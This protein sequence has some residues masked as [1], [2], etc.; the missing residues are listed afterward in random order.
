MSVSALEPADASHAFDGTR[1]PSGPTLRNVMRSEWTKLRSV[2]STW[3][4]LG[5]FLLI[6]LGL[7]ALVIWGNA[8]DYAS[9]RGEKFDRGGVVF[10]VVAFLGSL[11]IVVLGALTVTSEYSTGGIRTSLTAV[12]NRT[13]VFLAKVLVFGPLALALGMVGSGL[14]F[15]IAQPFFD[16]YD[17]SLSLSE[18]AVVRALIGTGIYVGLV[19]L[20]G[21]G[22]GFTLR[23]SPGAIATS[24]G[25][26]LVVPLLS[27]LLPGSVGH[28]ISRYFTSN[29]GSQIVSTEP[30]GNR[31][32]PWMG[33]GV[34]AIWALVPLVIGV[35]SLNRRDA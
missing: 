24:I 34:F 10:G 3:W 1:A 25:L 17:I 19:G 35:F 31:L 22:I 13:R 14:V 11:P 21:L 27:F 16:H 33:L 20:F 15:L 32:G 12:P 4:T 9:H 7:G 6:A 2:R 18:G 28:A 8:N 26:L 5:V 29:A 23:N 30:S